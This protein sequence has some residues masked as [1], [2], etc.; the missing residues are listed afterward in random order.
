MR[1]V[2]LLEDFAERNRLPVERDCPVTELAAGPENGV[3]HLTTS[4][5]M[6]AARNVV[7]AS[8]NLNVPR[9]PPWAAALPPGLHQIDASGYRS[10]ADL[11]KGAVLVVGSGQSGCQIAEDLAEAGRTVFLSTSRTGRLP[12]RYRGRDIMIWL[13][14]SGFLDVRR[15][16]IIQMAGPH[17]GQGCAWLDAYHKSS[18]PQCSG[19][20]SA[21]SDD[22]RRKEGYNSLSPMMWTTISASRTRRPRTLSDRSTSLLPAPELDAPAAEPDPAEIVAPSLPNPSIRTL[23]PAASGIT[24]VIWCAGFRGDFGWM[25]LPG[26]LDAEGQPLQED[27]VTVLPGIYFAGVDFGSTRKSGII[28]AIAEEAPTP[29]RPYRRTFNRGRSCDA[30]PSDQCLNFAVPAASRHGVHLRPLLVDNR[31]RWNDRNPTQSDTRFADIPDS[32]NRTAVGS[33]HSSLRTN[34]RSKPPTRLS[35]SGEIVMPAGCVWI[36]MLKYTSCESDLVW[37]LDGKRGCCGATKV[38]HAHWLAKL[39]LCETANN[40]VDRIWR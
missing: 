36:R 15:E 7:V 11:Q 17:S 12:R 35:A 2:A 3:Y 33:M 9:R 1:F 5:G 32:P 31:V 30:L 28:L 26:V 19:H 25:R 16:Q 37:C 22:G 18:V 20:R 14:Q 24:T 10:A 34:Y 29:R 23:D 6:L 21:W 4:R 27:G 38:V 13:V 40:L 8:G 39:L